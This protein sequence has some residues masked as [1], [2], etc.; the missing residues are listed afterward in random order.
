MTQPS[1]HVSSLTRH[2]DVL[3]RSADLL[4]DL[5]IMLHRDGSFRG[6]NVHMLLLHTVG[7]LSLDHILQVAL[8]EA[9]IECM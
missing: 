2:S 8:L 3:M 9:S 1:L 7:L 5:V 4:G 6:G